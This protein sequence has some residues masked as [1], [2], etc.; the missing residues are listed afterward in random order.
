MLLTKMYAT[1]SLS[2]I[3]SNSSGKFA[4]FSH[5]TPTLLFIFVICCS[6]PNDYSV[7][8]KFLKAKDVLSLKTKDNNTGCYLI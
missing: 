3:N 4:N 7:P 1:N 5:V 2:L 6:L 8:N